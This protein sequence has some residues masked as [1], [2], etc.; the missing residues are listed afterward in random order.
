MKIMAEYAHVAGWPGKLI[1]YNEKKL[2]VTWL[3]VA[4]W[5]GKLISYNVF[6]KICSG[7][8]VAGWPGKL[9]SYN[10]S[11]VSLFYTMNYTYQDVF[12]LPFF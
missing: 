5:P 3:Y 2:C 9:I 4:G 1:S 11:F 6:G 10:T 12:F 7:K 8:Y